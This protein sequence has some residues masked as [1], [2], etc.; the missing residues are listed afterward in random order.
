MFAYFTKK[1]ALAAVL[2]ML[3]ILSSML[4]SCGEKKIEDPAELFEYAEMKAFD[5]AAESLAEAYD[6][7]LDNA[8]NTK[9]TGGV[10]SMDIDLSEEALGM[11]QLAVNM[12]LSWL[13]NI[14]FEGKAYSDKDSTSSN[15]SLLLGDSRIADIQMLV[16]NS[17]SSVYFAVPE[18]LTKTL[19]IS[20][21]ALSQPL[22][23]FNF[24][25][26]PSGDTLVPLVKRYVE[27]FVTGIENVEKSE[28]TLTANGV[29][30]SCTVVKATLTPADAANIMKKMI[31]TAKTDTDLKDLI[32]KL[33]DFAVQIPN[34]GVESGDAL[35]T[36]LMEELELKLTDL[37]EYDFESEG[38]SKPIIIT[39]YINSKNEIIGRA[40]SNETGEFV[41]YGKAVSDGKFGFEVKVEEKT[42]ILGSGTTG[43][44]TSGTFVI[45]DGT[46]D[47]AEI[48]V[49]D[50]DEKLTKGTVDIKLL[51][52][53]EFD[54]DEMISAL[55]KVYS[56]RVSF[57]T[58]DDKMNFKL[59]VMNGENEFASFSVS[60]ETKKVDK[61]DIAT[62]DVMIID[63][64]LD[65]SA[66][67]GILDLSA[68]M[69][70]LKNSPVPSELV[71]MLELYLAMAG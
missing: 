71:S 63:E 22:N 64:D 61:L 32:V 11:L 49:K 12:D 1:K 69:E 67:L 52:G 4:V 36:S 62:D 59:S 18:A 31:E 44:T 57:E 2:A 5:S 7:Y 26:M 50:L 41:S 17:T 48:T 70:N 20:G 30:E 43:K 27:I 15:I 35:Y 45:G 19:K 58:S 9:G 42:V 38:D 21:D 47:Y 29:S 39:D 14:G 10:V 34:S 54:G 46:D 56:L 60:G 23:G 25:D 66:L 55:L 6:K 65:A 51:D 33:G 28:G 68:L 37:E 53:F 40:V 8:K 24:E 3:L 16:E 13:S